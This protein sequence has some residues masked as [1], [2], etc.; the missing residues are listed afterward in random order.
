VATQYVIS[1]GT[2]ALTTTVPKTVIEIPTGSTA[3]FQVVGME[4]VFSTVNPG[5]C[6][7][8]WGTYSVTGT[9]TTVTPLLFGM[10]QGPAAIL[11]TVK[12]NDSAE[13]T[14]FARGTLPSW[15]VPLPGMM[16]V[17]YPYTRELYQPV[18]TLRA[19]RLTATVTGGTNVQLNLT[20]E[21]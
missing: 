10:D 18:S 13:P 19:L 9:G 12:I 20:I 1:T 3:P 5:S 21:Q 7:V 14:S 16:S 11:G 4:L 17:L 15:C 6:V 2:I 8:E